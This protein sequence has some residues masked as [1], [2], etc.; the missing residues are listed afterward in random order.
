MLAFIQQAA[1]TSTSMCEMSRPPVG[2]TSCDSLGADFK[3]AV[4]ILCMLGAGCGGAF[5]RPWTRK[6]LGRRG[7]TRR[8]LGLLAALR[9][10]TAQLLAHLGELNGD[11]LLRQVRPDGDF[12]LF[13]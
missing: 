13:G 6:E 9:Q 11:C 8:R 10:V 1:D 5:I 4:A 12:T 3:S 7:F 2:A